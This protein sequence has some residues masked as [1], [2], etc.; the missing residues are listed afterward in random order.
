MSSLI[1]KAG[2]WCNGEVAYLAWQTASKIDDCLGFMIT[3]VHETGDDAGQRRILPTWIGFTD[4][5]NP[6]WQAQDSSVWPIQAFEWRDLT[7]R[8]SRDT[9]KVRPIDF[10]GHYEIV[11][12]GLAGP[13]RQPVPPS[14]TAEFNDA[15]GTARYVGPQH[16]L[17]IL[18]DPVV[19]APIDVT[20][21]FSGPN[22]PISATFTNG[23]ISTQ[24]LLQQLRSARP[25]KPGD[26]PDTTQG[27]LAELKT[28]IRSVQSP[29]RAFLTGDVLA[30]LRRLLDRAAN[31][32]GEVYLALYELDDP[33]LIDLLAEAVAAGRVHL[34]L[35]TAG[36]TKPS[37][38][39]TADED[40]QPVV[41]DTENNAARLRLQAIQ[42]A[43]VTDRMFNNSAHIGHDKFAVYVKNGPKAVMTGSTNWTST[44][45]CTQ[46]NNTIL[47]E[48]SDLAGH[49]LDFWQRLK[50]DPQPAREPL[51]VGDAVGA[52]ASR[53]VQG[54]ELRKANETPFGPVTLS[55]RRS[56]VTLWCSPNTKATTKTKTSKAPP[57]LAAVYDLMDKAKK[58]IFFLTFMPGTAGEQTIVG[59]A[60]RLAQARA[61]L[62]VLGAASAANALPGFEAPPK[63]SGKH[64]P[65]PSVY[66]PGGDKSRIAFIS[67]TAIATP[68]GDL[69]PELLSAGHAIIHD[70]IIVIDPLD[71]EACTVITGS[72]NLGF[73][74][75][76]TN[77]ENLLIIRGNQQLAIAYAVHVIDV[78][79]H[80]LTRAKIEQTA[81]DRALAGQPPPPAS[82][83][84]GFLK[85]D[86][87]WEDRYFPTPPA[88]SLSYFLGAAPPPTALSRS[89]AAPKQR[90]PR[91]QASGS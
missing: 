80:Y 12:V 68:V 88:S 55:D 42:G 87:S 32:E 64:V 78:Y 18:G 75:S 63:G 76:Y 82:V 48:D 43:D 72:H 49:Y 39:G 61:D 36:S 44:G 15:A 41:W 79:E 40:P 25:Q 53:G 45:L 16:Q 11:P 5:S 56:A 21:G 52:A 22:A 29:I 51:T 7:L 37:S 83:G 13:G 70:K 38:K 20:H 14:A 69:H 2:A 6:H 46:S 9:T 57:D 30:F 89:E 71:P 58:A 85:T 34:I 50:K 28:D 4:Q 24:N 33:E 26:D 66:W 3:R 91:R 67:A 84:H 47:I 1:T 23:I 81:R 65:A 17:F 77:D 54:Q 62:L 59:E 31:E 8:K 10:R 73:K 74:A 35:S 60:D 86:D 90:A 27:L 19:T